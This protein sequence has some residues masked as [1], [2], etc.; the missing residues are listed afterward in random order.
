MC[1]GR[2]SPRRLQ[3]PVQY[4][5]GFKD[6]GRLVD[7]ALASHADYHT[8]T[9]RPMVQNLVYTAAFAATRWASGYLCH[10]NG[11]LVKTVNSLL[12]QE[13]KDQDR[14]VCGEAV[15]IWTSV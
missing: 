1:S 2:I 10:R 4:S 14:E 12:H 11:R 15:K 13:E 5:L 8:S 6:L 7:Y 9:L 3:I